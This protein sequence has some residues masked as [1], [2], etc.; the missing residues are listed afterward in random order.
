[1][2][3][4]LIPYCGEKNILEIRLNELNSIVDKFIILEGTKSH[5]RIEKTPE[6]KIKDFVEFKDKIEYHSFDYCIHENPF[7]NDEQ[8]R[9]CLW[10][11][12]RNRVTDNDLI[13]GGDI[14]EI[15]NPEVLKREINNYFGPA[16]LL[17]KNRV[18]CLDLE[19]PNIKFPGTSI[20]DKQTIDDVGLNNLRN[21][22]QNS[23]YPFFK[24]IEN[25]GYHFTYCASLEKTLSKLKYF[26][27]APETMSWARTREDLINC[28]KSNVS[29]DKQTKLIRVPFTENNFP[30]YTINNKEKYKEI[31]SFNYE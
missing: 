15:C 12:I 2:I 31:L 6:F 27:H 18:L 29:I 7:H 25:G 9:I 8:G 10:N 20:L 19:Q 22:R 17:M 21:N 14:D 30:K 4:D 28:I 13:L 1:M 26:A 5:T 3:Y 16:T 11:I 23:H 24:L